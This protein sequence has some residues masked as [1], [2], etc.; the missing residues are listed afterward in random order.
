MSKIKKI[1][2][3]PI[4]DRVVITPDE[5]ESNYGNLVIPDI[6]KE[7]VSQGTVVAVGNGM[8]YGQG[9]IPLTCKPGD[10]VIFPKYGASDMEIGDDK[11]IIIKE[12][13][14]LTIVTE[15]D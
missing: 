12:N 10:K 9:L 15:Q 7:K 13:E 8:N 5:P 6:G 3:I 14:L 4:G 2:F 11:Y 1:L